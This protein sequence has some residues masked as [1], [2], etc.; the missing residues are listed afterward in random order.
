MSYR[1]EGDQVVLTMS[2]S[3]YDFLMLRERSEFP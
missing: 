2:R 1:E 3:D